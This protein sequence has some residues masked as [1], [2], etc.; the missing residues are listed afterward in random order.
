VPA[1]GSEAAGEQAWDEYVTQ[2]MMGLILDVRDQ[3][4]FAL[5]QARAITLERAHLRR[6]VALEKQ[7]REA[8]TTFLA[9]MSH[10][11]RTPLHAISACT[12]L[13]TRS[14]PLTEEQLDMLHTVQSSSELLRDLIN[15]I[16]D[17]SKLEVGAV[18]LEAK[19]FNLRGCMEDVLGVVASRVDQQAVRLNT[20]VD[21]S[22]PE[23]VVG[24]SMRFRQIVL[25]LASNAVKFCT[26][27]ESFLGVSLY[28]APA[29]AA[30]A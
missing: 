3:V 2:R 25:N 1:P 6:A 4:Y 20:V 14:R 29:R 8:G 22:L 5:E 21:P 17:A 16:L 19:A 15:D 7:R 18:E 11:M 13:L 12:D 23:L 10:E 26:A 28:E 24:D 27:G 30:R 9:V